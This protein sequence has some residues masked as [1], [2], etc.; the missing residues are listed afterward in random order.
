VI[1]HF[2]VTTVGAAVSDF[3]TAAVVLIHDALHAR[4]IGLLFV[5]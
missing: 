3:D 1:H 4:P 2:D 5:S